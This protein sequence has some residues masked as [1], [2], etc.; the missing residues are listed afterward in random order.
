MGGGWKMD[1]SWEK[2][3]EYLIQNFDRTLSKSLINK[4]KSWKFKKILNLYKKSYK[5][6][7]FKDFWN[8][9]EL[10]KCS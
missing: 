2:I 7:W 9:I 8:L 3:V 5:K 6:L 4:K 1:D 10:F